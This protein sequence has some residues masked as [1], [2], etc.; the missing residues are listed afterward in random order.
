MSTL[1]VAF[2]V[3]STSANQRYGRPSASENDREEFIFD[4]DE[5]DDD[6]E[7]M[8]EQLVVDDLN[9]GISLKDFYP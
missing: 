9:I 8:K 4:L 7:I 2:L 6:Q 5:D 3:M 1:L